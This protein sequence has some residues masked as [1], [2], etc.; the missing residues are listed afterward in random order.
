MKKTLLLFVLLLVLSLAAGCKAKPAHPLLALDYTTMDESGLVTYYND[1]GKE[2]D[3]CE[4]AN[5]IDEPLT[6]GGMIFGRG[7]MLGIGASSS[8]GKFCNTGK[9]RARRYS[10]RKEMERRGIEP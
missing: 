2:I 4:E 3:R 1:L 8:A 7:A 9:Y 5:E 6:G 10:V